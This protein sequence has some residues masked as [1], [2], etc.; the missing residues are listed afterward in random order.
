MN[1]E[2]IRYDNVEGAF[3]FSFDY[4]RFT[5]KAEGTKT[6]WTIYTYGKRISHFRNKEKNNTWDTA[7]IDLTEEF[8]KLFKDYNISISEDDLKPEILDIQASDFYKRFMGLITMTLQ[9]R[10]SD[11]EKGIDQI[12]SPVKNSKGEFFVSGS[13]SSLPVDADANG[14]YNIAKKGLWIIRKIKETPEDK[15]WGI[16][17]ALPNKEWLGFA[18]ENTI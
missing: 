13:D 5:Y 11:E 14:A 9:M 2:T 16:N 12:I 18:Q 4:E 6:D 1:M 17:L 15:I 8:S 10:N 7:Y 3:A